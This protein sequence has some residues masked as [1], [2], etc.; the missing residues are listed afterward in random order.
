MSMCGMFC[1]TY[2]TAEYDLSQHG[3]EA[4]KEYLLMEWRV[5]SVSIVGLAYNAIIVRLK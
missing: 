3:M 5:I 4:H 1:N 2:G